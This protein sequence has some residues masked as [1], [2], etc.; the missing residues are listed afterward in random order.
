[1]NREYNW[2]IKKFNEPMKLILPK[3]ITKFRFLVLKLDIF[4]VILISFFLLFLFRDVLFLPKDLIFSQGDIHRS[5]YFFQYFIK[6][7][8]SKGE[9]PYFNPKVFGG[10]P[11][12]FNPSVNMFYPVNWIL[13]LLPLNTAFSWHMMFHIWLA[14]IGMY[15]FLRLF[16]G[17]YASL[18]GALAYG[19]SF[20]F[21]AH[22]FA[23]AYDVIAGASYFPLV[24]FA[25]I[26]SIKKT[27]KRFF[28]LAVLIV[29]LQLLSGYIS[30][31]VMTLQAI[32]LY[33]LLLALLKRD[34][35]LLIRTGL[36]I[37]TSLGLFLF[38]LLPMLEIS[39]RSIR[40][41]P[42]E[43][44][45]FMFLEMTLPTLRLL[46]QPFAF[47]DQYNYKY[48]FFWEHAMYIGL[49][50]FMLSCLA[51]A[52]ISYLLIKKS[53]KDLGIVLFSIALVV[54]GILTS[55]GGNSPVNISGYLFSRIPWYTFLRI[56]PRHLLY[57]VF[58]LPVL[59]AF[60][61]D[62]IQKTKKFGIFTHFVLIGLICFTVIE[63]G[64][65]ARSFFTVT[66]SPEYKSE[67]NV[68]EYLRTVPI[69]ERIA[70]F[71][72]NKISDRPIEPGTAMIHKYSTISGY[73]V[74]IPKN[75]YQFLNAAN[76]L[77]DKLD[78]DLD[79]Y[80]NPESPYVDFLNVRYMIIHSNYDYVFRIKDKQKYELLYDT[81]PGS[82][83][84]YRLYKNLHTMPRYFIVDRAQGNLNR[85]EVYQKIQNNSFSVVEEVLL[86]VKPSHE[87]QVHN[88]NN[89]S[90]K[91]VEIL[92]YKNNS[93]V[94]KVDSNCG[95]Y[96]TS[97]DVY[98]PGW[99]AA[100]NGKSTQ[101]F[102][103]NLAFRTIYVPPGQ[104]T[105]VLRYTP[106]L[107]Y[108]G[109]LFSGSVLVLLIVYLNASF[110]ISLITI[111]KR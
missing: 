96:L 12:A 65:L 90:N 17:E 31:A 37:L 26:L 98:Y 97:S 72:I 48:W 64:L 82:L 94:L 77:R 84:S 100:V 8:L 43:S 38:Q 45:W 35:K 76:G 27:E 55:L 107:F 21:T 5:H 24:F 63:L 73:D 7:S 80:I 71:P 30:M 51:V 18:L 85:E 102:E 42:K 111:K 41:Y 29:L 16:F 1:M 59:A 99:T 70:M 88:C 62:F 28:F 89:N 67:S 52:L 32:G 87:I 54:F 92:E 86:T 6:D 23:G 34:I 58:G 46:V 20:R 95:G 101:V 103:G 57:V 104:H 33:V 9:M 93:I 3:Q 15:L 106:I 47:G 49:V 50:P 83:A 91:T 79:V 22:L 25:I 53:Y 13:Y 56:P 66:T 19:L 105:V 60:S 44:Y 39:L 2:N 75:F 78:N 74:V 14:I 68:F 11:F 69:T 36:I 109:L 81:D 40:S 4:I 108:A 10:Y 110:P 61:F